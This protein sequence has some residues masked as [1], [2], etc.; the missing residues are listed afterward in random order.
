[1]LICPGL[2]MSNLFFNLDIVFPPE[3][4]IMWIG[5]PYMRDIN[6]QF[7]Y[8]S[9]KK[10]MFKLNYY[11]FFANISYLMN[12]IKYITMFKLG[13]LGSNSVSNSRREFEHSIVRI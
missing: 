5:K 4:D 10:S 12:I 6:E 8:L 2:I 13:A 11:S 3:R 9:S 1:M 7:A